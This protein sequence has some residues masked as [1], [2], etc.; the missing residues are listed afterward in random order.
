MDQNCAD[1]IWN[2]YDCNKRFCP[3]HAKIQL[4]TCFPGDKKVEYFYVRLCEECRLKRNTQFG[5]T[6]WAICITIFTLLLMALA[7]VLSVLLISPK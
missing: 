3:Q 1:I 4:V 5:Q 2:V 7:V 6:K